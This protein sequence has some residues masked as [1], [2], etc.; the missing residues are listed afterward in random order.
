MHPESHVESNN[1]NNFDESQPFVLVDSKEA[2]IFA[3]IDK[4]PSSMPRDVEFTYEYGSSS[5]LGDSSHRGLGFSDELEGTSSGIEASTKQKEEQEES[6]F[7]YSEKAM[8]TEERSNHEVGVDLAEDF[9]AIM[10]SPK[11]NSGF[12]SIGGIKL[13][14]QDISDEESD[15][16]ENGKMVD[17]ESSDSS[18]Q[19]GTAGSSE[20]DDSEG[21]SDTDLD[22]DEEVAEDYIEGIGGSHNILKA[23]WLVEQEFD[24]SNDDTS[25]STGYDET[26]EKLGGVA[27]EEASRESGMKKAHPRQ[28]YRVS[29]IDSWSLAMDDLTIVKDPRTVYAKK[30]HVAHFPQSWPSEAYRSK[31]SRRFPGI[32]FL[33]YFLSL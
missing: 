20:S 23:K 31:M 30:K 10:L 15:E 33:R 8:N 14:T 21:M 26:L 16:D 22:V 5:V 13:Y 6:C 32:R 1:N 27:L 12:V 28:K 4:T 2:Q 25:S 18:E 7:D 17:E 9:P 24:E 19:G 29:A 3:Y 11:K